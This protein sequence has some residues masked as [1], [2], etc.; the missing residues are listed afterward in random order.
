MSSVIVEIRAG[1]GGQEAA[2]FVADLSK[3]YSKYA[4]SQGWKKKDLDSHFTDIGGLKQIIFELEN[5]DVFQKLKYE[6]GVHRVQRVPKTEKA[7]RV[8]TSTASVAVLK[9]PEKAEIKIKS[10]DLKIEFYG[11][12]GP[13]GQY[14]NKRETAVRITHLPTGVITSSQTRRNQLKNKENAMAILQAKLLEKKELEEFKK[15]GKERKSQIGRAKRVEKIRTY[16]FAQDRMTDHRIKKSWHNLD[17]IMAG[18]LDPVIKTLS[19]K[20]K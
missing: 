3:M 6:G 20:L 19:K 13:G 14:V 15:V 1:T 2:L 11:A 8:H 10:E 7:G 5:G 17:K 12:S 18:K 4:L 9:K 16:N